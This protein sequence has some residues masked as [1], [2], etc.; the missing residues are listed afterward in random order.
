MKDENLIMA[1]GGRRELFLDDGFVAGMSGN[2]SRRLH[3]PVADGIVMQSDAPHEDCNNSGPYDSV[4]YDGRRYLYYYR[5]GGRFPSPRRPE[6]VENYRLCVAETTDGI[7]FRRCD[8]KL[9][10]SGPNVVLDTTRTRHLV[11]AELKDI[12]AACATVFYDLN[13]RCPA[14]ERYKMIVTNERPPS[15]DAR[16]MYLFVSADGFDFHQK[17]G[18]FDLAPECGYDSANRAIYDPSI[19]EYRLY[20]RGF[21]TAGPDWK[22][23]IF[24][25]TTPDFVHFTSRGV[26]KFDP[27]FEALFA[28]GQELYTNNIAP[29]FRAPHI[30]LGLPMRYVEWCRTPGMHVT[31]KDWDEGILSRPDL[32][33]RTFHARRSPRYGL[34]ATDTVLISSRDGEH[35]RGFGESFVAAPPL[36]DSWKYGTG[37]LAGG[38]VVSPSPLGHGAP[39]E[40]SFYSAEGGW[41]DG[42]IRVRRYRLR[43][44]GFVSLHY[45][46]GGGYV[47]TPKFTFSGGML[48]L[49][50]ATGAL[51]GFQVEIQDEQGVP[52]PGYTFNDSYLECGDDVRMLARW[53]GCGNDLRPLEGKVIQLVIYGRN[54]DLYSLCFEPFELDPPLPSLVS[55]NIQD[56]IQKPQRS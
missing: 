54:C 13:P 6:T 50:I 5:G 49:N 47:Q 35:F 34:A 19:G 40:L 17:T 10:E 44:D 53:R 51:G 56:D 52:I 33:N 42:V 27:E 11:P 46:I 37:S 36:E 25:H 55:E 9:Y 23:T 16:G 7:H 43:M 24:L 38:M 14:E 20:S 18:K 28:Q 30:L 1:L 22:R 4:V 45:D 8:V 32:D 3:H 12:C 2:V 31:V 29:Y 41:G 15:G 48:S 21:M 26:L 39:D